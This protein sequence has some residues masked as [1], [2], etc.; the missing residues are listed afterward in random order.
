MDLHKSDFHKTRRSVMGKNKKMF[1]RAVMLLSANYIIN[2]YRY[3]KMFLGSQLQDH[4]S[5]IVKFLFPA[6][7]PYVT[8][9]TVQIISRVTWAAK[10]KVNC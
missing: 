5:V 2:C 7:K 10:V 8:F 9:L 6:I 4:Q 1:H 3:K